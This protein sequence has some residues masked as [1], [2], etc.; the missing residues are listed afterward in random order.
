M[1]GL[2]PME[3]SE[4]KGVHLVVLNIT[5]AA[6]VCCVRPSILPDSILFTFCVSVPDRIYSVSAPVFRSVP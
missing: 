3:V 1:A 4:A 6:V 2:T 5:S